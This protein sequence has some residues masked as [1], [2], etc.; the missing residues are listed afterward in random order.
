MTGQAPG[1]QARIDEARAWLRAAGTFSERTLSEKF[2]RDFGDSWR[3]NQDEGKW[4]QWVGTH[5]ARG[6]T[7]EFM[8]SIGVYA[9][10]LSRLF[11][12]IGE[13]TKSEMAKFQCAAHGGVDGADLP[14]DAIVHGAFCL[15]R[16]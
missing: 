7:P 15:V 14:V 6:Q 3:F 13:I 16:C 12:A 8:E 10:G 2:A 9:A 5:W 1:T 11:Y 4:L